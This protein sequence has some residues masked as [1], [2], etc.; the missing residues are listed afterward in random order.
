MPQTSKIKYRLIMGVLVVFA[1]FLGV[2]AFN[3]FTPAQKA[4]EKTVTYEKK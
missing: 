1:L 3:D 2:I 4:V